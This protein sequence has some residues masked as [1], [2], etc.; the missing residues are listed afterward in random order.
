MLIVDIQHPYEWYDFYLSG[1]V[2]K[3]WVKNENNTV[4]QNLDLSTIQILNAEVYSDTN[5]ACYTTMNDNSVTYTQLTATY[6]AD[7]KSLTLMD[8]YG[9]ALNV[10]NLQAVYFGN[11]AVDSN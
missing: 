2:L 7:K 10:F 4:S 9:F 5:F 11:S 8:Q 6:H 1:K 3:K